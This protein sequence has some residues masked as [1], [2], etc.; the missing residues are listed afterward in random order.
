[1]ALDVLRAVYVSERDV[2]EARERRGVH[3]VRAADGDVL[4]LRARGAR[5][6]LMRY[7]DGA[8]RG[9]GLHRADRDA[10]RVRIGISLLVGEKAPD[11][12]GL[13]KRQHEEVDGAVRVGQRH[14]LDL[15]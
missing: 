14:R 10:H 5:H 11:V 7:Q 15:P 8:P 1:M 6:E 4:G 2:V 9:V 3:V 13:E 12:R